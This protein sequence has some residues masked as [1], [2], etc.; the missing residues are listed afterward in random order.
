MLLL[1]LIEVRLR[2]DFFQKIMACT[3]PCGVNMKMESRRE[4]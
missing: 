2:P 3:P 1:K 4:R